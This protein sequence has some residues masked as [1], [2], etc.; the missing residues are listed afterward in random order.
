MQDLDVSREAIFKDKNR[1]FQH[2]MFRFPEQLETGVFA[3]AMDNMEIA[4][5]LVPI[6]LK[7]VKK[8]NTGTAVTIGVQRVN[9]VWPIAASAPAG[10][11]TNLGRGSLK[12]ASR[13]LV[14][15]TDPGYFSF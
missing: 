11:I 10:F 14:S 3:D 2:Q 6:A 13:A 15:Y 8:S 9:V 4:P 12:H 7:H 5:S 1:I